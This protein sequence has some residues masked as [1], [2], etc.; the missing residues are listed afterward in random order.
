[1]NTATH[2]ND[3]TKN[4][5][6]EADVVDVEAVETTA[7]NDAQEQGDWAERAPLTTAFLRKFDAARNA[8]TDQ[9]EAGQKNIDDLQKKAVDLVSQV[10]QRAGKVGE[11]VTEQ[12]K[13][14]TTKLDELRKGLGDKFPLRID[15]ES[16]LNLPVEA[17]QEVL[18]VL[19]IAS[20]KQVKELQLSVDKLREET[21]VLVEAQTAVLKEII[22][23]N[24]KAAP[25]KAPA[26]KPAPRRATKAA[27]KTA[28]KA[29]PKT[30]AARKPAAKKTPARKPAAKKTAPAAKA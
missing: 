26:R 21:I 4:T 12:G 1:M 16:W 23:N 13:E 17:R 10:Q 22:E 27:P 29:A 15:L 24:A 20:D 18:T 25:K 14:A 9:L 3:N 30:A 5:A 7:G 2:S 6:P 8:I 19:G 11:K 28:T